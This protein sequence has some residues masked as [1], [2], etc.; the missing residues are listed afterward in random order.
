LRLE[1]APKNVRVSAIEPGMVDTELPNHGDDPD[2]TNRM[3][4]L[5]RDIDV[6]QPR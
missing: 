1:L 4:N 3:A 2:A 6:L 5:I